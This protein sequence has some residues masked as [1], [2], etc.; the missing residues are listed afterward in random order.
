[1]TQR[2]TNKTETLT[3]FEATLV[4]Q[5]LHALVCAFH[6]SLLF[7]LCINLNGK[8][9]QAHHAISSDSVSIHLAHV[10]QSNSEIT[11]RKQQQQQKMMTPLC[12]EYARG[13]NV[14]WCVLLNFATLLCRRS[15]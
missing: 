3:L 11:E 6:I 7:N 8:S 15:H 10:C 14:T 2:I 5:L 9:T 12:I 4:K 1:M 13:D